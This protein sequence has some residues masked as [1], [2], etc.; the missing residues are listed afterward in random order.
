MDPSTPSLSAHLS[1]ARD[2]AREQLLAAWQIHVERVR[3]QLESGW[4]E[5]L[6]QIFSDRFN[7]MQEQL[8]HDFAASVELHAEDKVSSQL[9]LARTSAYVVWRALLTRIAS[10][11][12]V[13]FDI[14]GS[15]FSFVKYRMCVWLLANIFLVCCPKV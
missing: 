3:D 1:E 9:G 11:L 13:R 12:K 2:T 10:A 5:Q 4:Q 7:E 6:D 8:E 15:G 14:P